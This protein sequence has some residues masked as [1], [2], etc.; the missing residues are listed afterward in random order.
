[1]KQLLLI[2]FLFPSALL[3]QE[4]V[5][6]PRDTSYTIHSAYEKHKRNYPNISVPKYSL[7][8]GMAQKKDLI[9]RT[10]GERNLHL[11]INYPIN[12]YEKLYPAILLIHGGGWRTGDK[13]LLLP[14]AQQL[15]SRGF[16]TVVAEYRL[17]LEAAF[18]AAVQDLKSAISWM[19]QNAL[20]YNIDTSQIA[21]LGCSAG[22][23]LAALIGT[24]NGMGKLE[25]E[26]ENHHSSAVQAI[27]DIDGILAFH[28]PESEEGKMAAQWLG[29]D[30]TQVPEVWEEASALSHVDENTPPVLFIGSSFPRFLAG[31]KDMVEVLDKYDIYSETHVFEEA[32][33]SF[34]LFNPWFKPT[35]K[36]VE[37]FLNRVLKK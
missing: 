24:T 27:V 18:P 35:V 15:A 14:M 1:M 20:T 37:E 5:T 26:R 11:D 31:R 12:S 34:W 29:G 32:P 22:G 19:R 33:H 3:A 6:Y 21:V 17:S 10:I 25:V 7:P 13:S 2:M 23:Q 30:Y 28:H 9:Y 8:E 4:S 16:V 36:Y